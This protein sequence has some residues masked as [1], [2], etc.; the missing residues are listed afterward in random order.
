MKVGD[1]VR[2]RHYHN[3][4]RDVRGI[5]CELRNGY[6]TNYTD[7]P[8]RALVFWNHPRVQ[9]NEVM[10]WIDDLEVISESR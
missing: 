1:L 3:D 4:L 5:V 7:R 9:D 2:Y 8:E 6:T 10:D